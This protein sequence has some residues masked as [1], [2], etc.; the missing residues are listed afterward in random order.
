MQPNNYKPFK[1]NLSDEIKRYISPLQKI[2]N[3]SYINEYIISLKN[4]ILGVR[5]EVIFL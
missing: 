5:S 3:E 2:Y 1:R 4:Q